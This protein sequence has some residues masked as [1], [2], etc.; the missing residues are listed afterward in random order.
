MNATQKG[1]TMRILVL[2]AGATGGYFGGRLLE[3]GR[4]VSFMVR[5]KRAE[6]LCRDGL[7]IK[8]PLGDTVLRQPPLVVG[9]PQETFDVIM[10][11][12]KAF[13]LGSA[14]DAISP[15]MGSATA[16]I[17]LLNGMKHIEVLQER[18]GEDAIMGGFCAIAAT[19]D[20]NGHILHL[21]K[22][23]VLRF[24]ELSG[25]LSSRVASMSEQVNSTNM[26]AKASATII[27]DMWEKWVM[28]ASLAGITCLMRGSVGAILRSPRGHELSL[29]LLQECESVAAAEGFP[30]RDDFNNRT[31]KMLSDRE[32]TLT[33]S[34]LRDVERGNRTEADHVLGDMILRA[35]AKQLDVPLL[36]IAFC[37]LKVYESER[38]P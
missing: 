36:R 24:G 26:D 22:N 32:S 6:E 4:D 35:E 20:S 19:L 5:S 15:A 30:T 27:H 29:Q 38:Q 2:G 13:D 28:L 37:N 31:L 16:I 8:S 25:V 12:C 3:A 17:P 7:V 11:S 14:I 33:A 21:N 23:H 10:L 1:C 34:M 9:A 18:F